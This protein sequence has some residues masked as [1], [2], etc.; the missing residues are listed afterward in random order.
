MC[1]DHYTV[2]PL[3]PPG[4]QDNTLIKQIEL[5]TCTLLSLVVKLSEFFY[6]EHLI[7]GIR[8]STDKV[9][10]IFK[11]LPCSEEHVSVSSH[12]RIRDTPLQVISLVTGDS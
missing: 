5:G 11:L 1:I 12:V 8:G 2:C 7:A 3:V 10:S 6:L 4:F 9:L